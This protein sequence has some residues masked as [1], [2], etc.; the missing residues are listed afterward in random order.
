[1][2]KILLFIKNYGYLAVFL[3]SLIEGESIVLSASALSYHGHLNLYKVMLTAF[4]GTWFADQML[5][6]I[7]RKY[8]VALFD[9]FPRLKPSAERAFV[10]LKRWDA[11]FIIACRFIYGIRTTS[12]IVVGAS[13][14]PPRRFVPL[15]ILSALIWTI[16]SCTGGYFL[17][18][19]MMQIFE[20]FHLIQKYFL[21][22]IFLFAFVIFVFFY[23]RKKIIK[24]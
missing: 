19:L 5:Y 13:G 22:A 10:L 16:V 21:V 24:S 20:N 23:I 12:C 15:N 14:I 11:G 1:M 3:G 18:P 2:E 4:L 9:R 8:G 6:M 7:G 17:G